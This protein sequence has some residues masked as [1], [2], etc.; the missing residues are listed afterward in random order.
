MTPGFSDDKSVK[1][2]TAYIQ[3]NTVYFWFSVPFKAVN[4]DFQIFHLPITTSL[5]QLH[6]L[7]SSFSK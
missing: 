4:I 3:A 7:D 1:K 6:I 5:S 2:F